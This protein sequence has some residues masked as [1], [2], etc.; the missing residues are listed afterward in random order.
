M[1]YQFI[2]VEAYSRSGNR[3][4]GHSVDAILAEAR[5]ESDACLHVTNPK[6]PVLVSGCDLQELGRRHGEMIHAARETLT[7]GKTRAVRKDTASLFTCVISH[8]ATPSE[9]RGDPEVMR[10]VKAWAK[11]SAAWLR[12]DVEQRGGTLESVIM[13]IDE[14]HVHLHAYGLHPSGHADRLHA[15][16]VAKKDS[17]A[18]ALAA[19]HDKK[20]ANSIG[21]K[22]YVESMRG[23][24]DAYSRDVGLRHGL[25]RLGPA[26]RRLSRAEWKAEQ[27]AAK[28]V[29]AARRAAE[30][31]MAGAIRARGVRDRIV[32][33]GR[34]KA[35]LLALQAHWEKQ[36]ATALRLAAGNAAKAARMDLDRARQEQAALLADAESKARRIKTLGGIIRTLWDSLRVSVIR[37]RVMTDAQALIDREAARARNLARRL[38]DEIARRRDIERR[39]ADATASALAAGRERDE[40]R[41]RHARVLGSAADAG[42]RIRPISR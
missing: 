19:G 35:R 30:G 39:L 18:A 26:R 25:T 21:D 41:V 23:W 42:T 34:Q 28:S 16:K 22:S 15:G 17:V 5:R 31:A 20:A 4:G 29:L 1:G 40:I 8:P 37:R 24:Q 27:A 2:H 36:E 3:E 9:C 10:S 6:P 32:E 38:Q 14:S 11:D 12:R 33:N 7:N 13:H